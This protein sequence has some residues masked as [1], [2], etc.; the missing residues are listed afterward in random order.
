M[1]DCV[2]MNRIASSSDAGDGYGDANDANDD[3]NDDVNDARAS[4]SRR[5]T[6]NERTRLI[7]V[8]VVSSFGKRAS[9]REI[10]R[11][12]ERERARQR[13]GRRWGRSGTTDGDDGRDATGG[14]GDGR[15]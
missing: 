14:E 4:V 10:E 3:A 13:Q 6:S 12:K 5:A 15:G 11:K 7:V 1:I 2:R 8:E 9:E